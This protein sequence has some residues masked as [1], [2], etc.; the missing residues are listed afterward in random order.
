MT[1]QPLDPCVFVIFGA[2]GDLMR[3]KLLPALF[4]SHELAAAGPASILGVAARPWFDDAQ[5]ARWARQALVEAQLDDGGRRQ[6]WCEERSQLSAAGRRH[7]GATTGRSPSTSD[8]LEQMHQLPGQPASYLALPPQAFPADDRR[9]RR[10][11]ASNRS[12]GWTRLVIEKP[13]GRD[14]DSAGS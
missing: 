5:F 3:R 9:A 13:F 7:G 6:R 2:T 12:S 8:A 10:V 1:D 11:P 4:A 14:L